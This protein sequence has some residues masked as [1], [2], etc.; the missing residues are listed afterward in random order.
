MTY[1]LLGLAMPFTKKVIGENDVIHC[2]LLD[3]RA[4]V[5]LR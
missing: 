3:F 4:F 1:I 2:F 5:P